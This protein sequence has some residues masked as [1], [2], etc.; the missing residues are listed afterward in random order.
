M[1]A[2]YFQFQNCSSKCNIPIRVNDVIWRSQLW[3][4]RQRVESNASPNHG[5]GQG[6]PKV[7]GALHENKTIYCD[8]RND[9]GKIQ[10]FVSNDKSAVKKHFDGA[11]NAVCWRR[12]GDLHPGRA[13]RTGSCGPRTSP[14][15]MPVN[16]LSRIS[17]LAEPAPP[18]TLR[19]CFSL[20]PP[21]SS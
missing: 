5:P 9:W 11:G 6:H 8:A 12:L 15:R 3:S 19:Q 16:K 20:R 21:T 1:R 4:Q 7:F 10:A 13:T 18:H 17:K 2:Q 14:L